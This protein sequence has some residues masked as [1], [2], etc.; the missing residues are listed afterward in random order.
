MNAGK[1]AHSYVHNAD[2]KNALIVKW[3]YVKYKIEIILSLLHIYSEVRL[4]EFSGIYSYVGVCI[5][6]T[7]VV[8][9]K[10]LQRNP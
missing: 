3:L 7:V 9:W 5:W 4:F 8:N 6:Y 10:F 2:K 1:I